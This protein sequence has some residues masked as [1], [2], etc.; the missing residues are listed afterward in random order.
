MRKYEIIS[1]RTLKAICVQTTLASRDHPSSPCPLPFFGISIEITARFGRTA[2]LSEN[3]CETGRTLPGDFPVSSC[4][5]K[6]LEI[7][8]QEKL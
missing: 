6:S 5:R 1:A 3:D 4:D 2:A 8:D 7:E